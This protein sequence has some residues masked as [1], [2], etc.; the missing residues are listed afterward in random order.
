MIAELKDS[1]IF[2][3]FCECMIFL[4]IIR[5]ASECRGCGTESFRVNSELTDK[6]TN[7]GQFRTIREC[8]RKAS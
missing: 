5:M 8:I 2:M 7:V 3:P 6:T 4:P 1:P